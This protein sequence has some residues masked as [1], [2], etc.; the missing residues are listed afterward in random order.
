L[1][2]LPA[3]AAPSATLLDG[4]WNVSEPG[5]AMPGYSDLLTFSWVWFMLL[6]RVGVGTGR[7]G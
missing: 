5:H 4:C 1:P 7:L 2:G 6:G 3:R